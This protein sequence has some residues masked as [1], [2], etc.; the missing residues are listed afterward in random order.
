MRSHGNTPSARGGKHRA[1]PRHRGR[2]VVLLASLSGVLITSTGYLVAGGG[3]YGYLSDQQSA[4]ITITVGSVPV[5]TKLAAAGPAP[6][7]PTT[8]STAGPAPAPNQPAAAPPEAGP[9]PAVAPLAVAPPPAAPAP[10]STAQL[11][12]LLV[13]TL[14]VQPPAAGQRQ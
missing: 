3:T 9:P 2:T 1:P 5:A 4:H 13:P 8:S 10:P 6:V 14:A 12:T 11:P 7:H